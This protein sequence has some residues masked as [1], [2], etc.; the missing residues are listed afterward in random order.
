MRAENDQLILLHTVSS[1]PTPTE[2][3]NLRVIPALIEKFQ[4]P[5]GLSDHTTGIGAACAAVALG[6]R[7]FEKHF[8]FDRNAP[9]PDHQ[10]SLDPD[11]IKEYVRTV[12]SVY[13]GLGDGVKRVLPCE[14]N[15][16]LTFR[17]FLVSANYIPKGHA[18]TEDDFHFKKTS[19]GIPP[20]D[21]DRIV[22][23]RASTDIPADHLIEWSHVS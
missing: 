9:G 14:E 18:F 5:V 10:A 3:M 15:V 19:R 20:K 17:R 12:R 6:A 11:G 2:S 7:I 1:Y 4:L 22:G 16:R 23:R 21:M 8:T 13:R